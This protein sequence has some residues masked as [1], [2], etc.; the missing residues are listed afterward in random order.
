[1]RKGLG[2]IERRILHEI[3]CDKTP[4]PSGEPGSVLLNSWT[5]ACDAFGRGTAWSGSPSPAQRKAVCRAMH[6]FVRKFPQ[7]ALAGGK[8][9][10]YLYLF[11]PGDP[12][13][14]EWAKLSVEN[15]NFVP[16]S[17]AQSAIAEAPPGGVLGQ[18]AMC[19]GSQPLA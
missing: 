8:G 15:R 18:E 5:L 13:S 1:M 10:K 16:C 2:R 17:M 3:A 12:V 9:R 14:A 6:S 11:E 19:Q 4:G 7:Y